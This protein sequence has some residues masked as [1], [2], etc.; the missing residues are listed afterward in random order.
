MTTNHFDSGD[1]KA[2]MSQAP[3][4]T[5]LGTVQE[6]AHP[7]S[8]DDR[9]WKWHP[10][11]ELDLPDD[12]EIHIGAQIRDDG[13]W[14]YPIEGATTFNLKASLAGWALMKHVKPSAD[15]GGY[16]P[17]RLIF[18]LGSHRREHFARSFDSFKHLD[19]PNGNILPELR[20][21]GASLDKAVWS[22]NEFL[23]KGREIAPTG[24]AATEVIEHGI[25]A[26]ARCNPL[27]LKKKEAR[28]NVR[29]GIFDL[30]PDAKVETRVVNEVTARFLQ[31]LEGH[32]EDTEKKFAKWFLQNH[33]QAVKQIAKKRRGGRA[34]QREKVRL[35]ILELVF[36]SF[37]YMSQSID[38]FGRAFRQTSG[39][40]EDRPSRDRYTL[41]FES[42]PK[43][44]GFPLTLLQ[45][46]LPYFQT[47]I[48]DLFEKPN[49]P[50]RF[51]VFHSALQIRGEMIRNRRHADSA[52]GAKNNDGRRAKINGTETIA[53]KT[54]PATSG[55][56]SFADEIFQ[57][58][59]SKLAQTL[60]V[61][62]D[63]D[64]EFRH[65]AI[66]KDAA[67]VIDQLCVSSYCSA[68]DLDFEF[69]ATQSNFEAA[70]I[71]AKNELQNR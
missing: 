32:L 30:G 25:I 46:Q 6:L 53:F 38:V 58:A 59:A 56:G 42:Q 17:M 60:D 8:T 7:S 11:G 71:N 52:A 12:F 66:N 49:D 36:R 18:Q 47:L 20:N 69:S 54:L 22:R 41:L 2:T 3:I 23:T 35:A 27:R 1:T 45:S 50:D 39:M 44:G 55:S 57:L 67:P 29:M 70:A 14:A 65:S 51:A 5:T 37:R 16:H 26:A 40:F 15:F 43:L 68:C 48:M 28:A 19:T 31:L 64:P 34:I 10:S 63:C 24:A 21:A 4:L 61:G 33:D 9:A 62:C 13:L